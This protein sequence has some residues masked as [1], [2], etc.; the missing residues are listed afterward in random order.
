MF[1]QTPCSYF[2]QGVPK[3]GPNGNKHPRKLF[4]QLLAGRPKWFNAN[5][6]TGLNRVSRQEAAS[7]AANIQQA[8]PARELPSRMI[9]S[10][11]LH[12]SVY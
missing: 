4:R 10:C 9:D 12:L 1:F 2:H 8:R 11:D 6:I 7:H 5:D 3:P